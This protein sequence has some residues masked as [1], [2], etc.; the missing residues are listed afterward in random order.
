MLNETIVSVVNRAHVV[1]NRNKRK[2]SYSIY[3]AVVSVCIAHTISV[4]PWHQC[5]AENDRDE[6]RNEKCNMT[7]SRELCLA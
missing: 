3:I 2:L 5:Q 4:D 6:N 1:E 7:E